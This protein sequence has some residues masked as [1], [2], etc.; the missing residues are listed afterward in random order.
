VRIRL[1]TDSK[2]HSFVSFDLRRRFDS[3]SL[4][5]APNVSVQPVSS[6]LSIA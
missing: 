5:S 6:L 2:P 1:R 4:V 3:A